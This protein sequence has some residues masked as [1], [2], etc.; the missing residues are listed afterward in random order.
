ML[1]LNWKDQSLEIKTRNVL[2]TGASRG[3]GRAVAI[4]LA[5]MNHKVVINYNSHENEAKQVVKEKASKSS[6]VSLVWFVDNNY[7]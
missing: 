4:K 7:N 1:Y 5:S 2:I 6:F 3:I